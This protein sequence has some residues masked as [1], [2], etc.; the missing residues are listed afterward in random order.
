MR[1]FRVLAQREDFPAILQ[2]PAEHIRSEYCPR[3]TQRLQQCVP[4]PARLADG[5]DQDG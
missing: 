5:L 3:C 1:A 4:N 2:Q